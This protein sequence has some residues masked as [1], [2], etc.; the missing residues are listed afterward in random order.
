MHE[1]FIVTS[2]CDKGSSTFQ[3]LLTNPLAREAQQF[4]R[5]LQSRWQG[6][7]NISDVVCKPD[8]GPG[9][10]LDTQLAPATLNCVDLK[11]WPS[12]L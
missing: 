8:D 4:R 2:D 9:P 5:C 10:V 12:D 11:A 7:L 3:T 6:K 1:N